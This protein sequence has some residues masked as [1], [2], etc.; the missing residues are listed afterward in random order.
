MSE[1]DRLRWHCR[2]GL[3]ELDLVLSRFLDRQSSTLTPGQQSAFKTLLE[4]SDNDLW[5]LVC[6]R[7]EPVHPD[8][9]TQSVLQLLRTL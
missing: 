9:D 5:D 7:A 1:A 6:G 4:C 8:T 2:R 3:L